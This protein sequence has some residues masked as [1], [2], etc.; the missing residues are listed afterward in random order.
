MRQIDE[1]RREPGVSVGATVVSTHQALERRGKRFL[2]GRSRFKGCERRDAN[3]V[4][5]NLRIRRRAEGRVHDDQRELAVPDPRGDI[6]DVVR[7]SASG[8]DRC[9][10]LDQL[11][12][13][14]RRDQLER[15]GRDIA[16]VLAPSAIGHRQQAI[17]VERDI[18]MAARQHRRRQVNRN[19]QHIQADQPLFHHRGVDR[20]RIA[21]VQL[22]KDRETLVRSA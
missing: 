7:R 6:L 9:R 12:L 22:V 18:R 3:I 21:A 2:L 19:V 16:P 10:S 17:A 5:L 1:V 4:G 15:A 14:M 8:G 20:P 11:F 13:R